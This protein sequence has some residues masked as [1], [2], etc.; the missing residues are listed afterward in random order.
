MVKWIPVD[1]ARGYQVLKVH[2]KFL[3]PF[4]FDKE[5]QY[6]EEKGVLFSA[7]ED[8]VL[9]GVLVWTGHPMHVTIEGGVEIT[10]RSYWGE[11]G[12][13]PIFRRYLHKHVFRN[14]DTAAGWGLGAGHAT[15]DAIMERFVPFTLL[16]E[17]E[18]NLYYHRDARLIITD[19]D[20]SVP[21][22]A[23]DV[24]IYLLL[25]QKRG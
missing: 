15:E 16:I 11:E 9:L 1:Q 10:A 13:I 3:E 8:T 6:K 21:V 25:A 18:E 14:Y 2:R 7:E 5:N 17:E 24:D 23:W 12:C 20:A 4:H 22:D 19:T